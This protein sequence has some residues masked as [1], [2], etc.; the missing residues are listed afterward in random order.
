MSIRPSSLPALAECPRFESDPTGSEHTTAGTLRHQVFR[1]LLASVPQ[2]DA[3]PLLAA[4]KDLSEEDVDGVVWAVEYV[5]I[6]ANLADHPLVLEQRRAF[7]GPDFEEI[8]GTPDA[9]CG[10]DIFDLKWRRSDYTAQMAAYALMLLQMGHGL[11]RV[12]VLYAESKKAE[13][14]EFDAAKATSLVFGIIERAAA[15]EAEPS[16]CSFCGWCAKR[17]T[18]PAVL[19]QVNAVVANREDFNLQTWHASEIQS[20][21]EMGKALRIART[22]AEWCESV[23]HHAK[24]MAIKKGIIPAGFKVQNRQGNRYV[25]SLPDAFAKAGLPQDKFLAACEIKLS[26]LAEAYMAAN[27]MKKAPAERELEA[28]LGDT[29]Q[30]KPSTVSLVLEK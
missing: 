15:L 28:K 23:E 17:L 24:D 13:V 8:T 12:H 27:G 7:T 1:D 22:V 10:S 19:K 9:I 25:A 3:A 29:I 11:V 14:I 26:R 2:E 30:R 6:K 21:E 4:A 5:R 20:G 16:A 18:C